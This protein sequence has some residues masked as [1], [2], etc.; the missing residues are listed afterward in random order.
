MYKRLAAFFLKR[1]IVKRRMYRPGFSVYIALGSA[2][3]MQN[4]VLNLLAYRMNAVAIGHLALKHEMSWEEVPP[5]EIYFD[6]KHVIEGKATGFTN[7]AIE[8]AVI[9]CRALLEF[10]G[11]RAKDLTRLFERGA[12]SKSDDVGI[13]NSPSVG[14]VTI[15]KAVSAYPGPPVEAEAALAYVIH[16]ANKGLAHTTGSFKPHDGGNRLL[17]IAFRGVPALMI[18]NFYTPQG[19]PSPKY[20]L[21]SRSR[22]NPK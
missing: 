17:E 7:G 19:M 4:E 12:L 20:E 1:C 13:E 9:H 8:A 2:P 10:M 16:V 6:E 11:L 5:M 15:A 3:T 21:S 22:E 18:N 14:R